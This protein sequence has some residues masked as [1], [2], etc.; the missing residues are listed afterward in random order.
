MK[1]ILTQTNNTYDI[2]P[3][4]GVG[5]FLQPWSPH[6]GTSRKYTVKMHGNMLLLPHLHLCLFSSQ[7]GLA[8]P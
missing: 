1:R 3:G 2:R 4:N 8:K 5:L 6:G 7:T